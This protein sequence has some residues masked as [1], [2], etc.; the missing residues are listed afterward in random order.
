VSTASTETTRTGQRARLG[1]LLIQRGYLSEEQLQNAL[2]R[3]QEIGST[4][5]L[6]ELLVEE[7]TCSEDQV[8]E[9]LAAEYSVPYAKLDP[10]IVDPKILEVLPREFLEKQAVLPLFKVHDD[11]T[12]AMSEPANVFLL[13][14]LARIT[15]CRI[16]VVA[17]TAK[18][19]RRMLQ[20]YLPNANVFVIDDIIDDSQAAD[21][22]LIEEAPDDIGDMQEVAGQSPVIRLV[23]YIIYNGVKNGASDIHIEPDD[24]RM[25]VRYRVDGR[26]YKTL[27]PPSHLH[28]AV[29]SR[30]KIMA[31][32][33][34][35]ERRMPQDGRIHVLME[36]QP[37]DLRVSTFPTAAGEKTVIRILDNRNLLVSLEQMGF[38]AAILENFKEQVHL[39][40]GIA[41]VTGP[42]GS[43]KSTTLY[44]ALQEINSMDVNICTIEDPV[45][46]HLSLVNQ[47]HV[48]E[49]I[50]LTFATALRSILRQDPDVIMVG[51][52]RDKETARTAIQ[53]ALTGHLV[54]STLHTNDACS[55]VTRLINMGVE[56]YL[57][58]ASL[59]MALAQRLVRRICSKCKRPY[60][61]DRTI[62]RVVKAMG[63]QIDEFYRGVGCKRCRNTG[64]TGRIGIHELL[65]LTD[66]ISDLVIGN[67][68][69]VEIRRAAQ[70][71]GM[72]SMRWDGLQKVN[73]GLTTCEEV[74]N[75]SPAE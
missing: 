43:G 27:E 17:T 50:G 65:L 37:I 21:V 29:T 55:T 63:F 45:E 15:G 58:A 74:F 25:R 68:S 8:I 16:Q 53:S 35:S 19:I 18:D 57:I 39:P 56:P 67:P 28:P 33:D 49:K 62:R 12:V 34:I 22:T 69:T 73:E 13:D 1:E 60:E 23:N 64:Y 9:C 59:N 31:N 10:K 38:S 72:K 71:N 11:L 2:A 6:G 47:F 61:P 14:E 41:L 20:T 24:K 42:T 36:S 4:Q 46:Y 26:L 52:I 70:Q 40:S 66:E 7:G 3:Q 32:M 5:L 30:I 48:N 54:F 75:A 44:G 51:E